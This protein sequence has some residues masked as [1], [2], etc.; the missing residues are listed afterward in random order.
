MVSLFEVRQDSL[1][2]LG[3]GV[4]VPQALLRM[5]IAP[6]ANK[7]DLLALAG[8][9]FNAKQATI[10]TAIAGSAQN[11]AGIVVTAPSFGFTV[12]TGITVFPHRFN[13]SFASMAGTD[14]EIVI[15]YT[16]SD[17]FTSGG[18]ACSPLNLRSDNPRA[19]SVTNCKVAAGAAIVEAAMTNVRALYQAVVPLAFTFATSYT[20]EKTL[21]IRWENFI[22]I[23]GPAR[24]LFWASAN[25][26]ASTLYFNAEWAEIPTVAAVTGV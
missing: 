7:W 8:Y 11:A 26:T 19:T 23:V 5:G 12:P 9:M 3:D 21:D 14:N 17:S 16:D 20:L 13:V 22:P 15:A 1:T 18:T 10:G 25:T 24:F 2:S 4:V 6:V